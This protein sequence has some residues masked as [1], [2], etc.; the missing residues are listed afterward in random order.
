M[1]LL[2]ELQVERSDI[3][4]PE[5][6][7]WYYVYFRDRDTQT[8]KYTKRQSLVRVEL[9]RLN[10]RPV[11]RGT[12][13]C[14]NHV[15]YSLV[16]VARGGSGSFVYR[17][18]RNCEEHGGRA[19]MEIELMKFLEEHGGRETVDPMQVLRR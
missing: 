19:K 12:D 13:A 2:S 16:V 6:I 9:R 11:C 15:D 10:P 14:R 8:G 7:G 18:W 3:A 5:L 1:T 17:G 4:E